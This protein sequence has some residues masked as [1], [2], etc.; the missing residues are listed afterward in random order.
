[1]LVKKDILTIF[2]N[3]KKINKAFY[4]AFF[5]E[6]PE[7]NLT[8][9]FLLSNKDFSYIA[10]SDK[11]KNNIKSSCVIGADDIEYFEEAIK[12]AD[13]KD[14]LY[15]SL[16]GNE[17][18]LRSLETLFYKCKVELCEE[19]I[20]I[21]KISK[22]VTRPAKDIKNSLKLLITLADKKGYADIPYIYAKLDENIRFYSFTPWVASMYKLGENIYSIKDKTI[23]FNLDGLNEVISYLPSGVNAE[24]DINISKDGKLI[25]IFNNCE[26]VLQGEKSDNHSFLDTFFNLDNDSIMVLDQEKL[27]TMLGKMKGIFGDTNSSFIAFNK[28]DEKFVKIETDEYSFKVPYTEI[29]GDGEINVYG[30]YIKEAASKI[31]SDGII[32]MKVDNIIKIVSENQDLIVTSMVKRDGLDEERGVTEDDEESDNSRN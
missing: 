32:L 30:R 23:R 5:N 9:D 16:E 24:C 2:R 21:N 31:T 18:S 13:A 7:E 22:T 25:F 1:M 6:K 15:L 19:E 14:N 29:R 20:E 8:D 11:P 27:K 26:T 28:E 10:Y 12:N 17:L 3:I 4:V